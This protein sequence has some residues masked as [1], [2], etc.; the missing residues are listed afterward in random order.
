MIKN[1]KTVINVVMILLMN[2]PKYFKNTEKIM[3]ALIF[4]KLESKI[5]AKVSSMY[6]NK[7]NSQL[8]KS[9]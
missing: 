5:Y 2:S 9:K 1:N 7:I 8:N 6:N 3:T 4:G